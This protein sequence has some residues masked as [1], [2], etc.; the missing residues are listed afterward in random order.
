MENNKIQ[1]RP[2]RRT[3]CGMKLMTFLYS[4]LIDSKSTVKKLKTG[5]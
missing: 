1:K 4:L 5:T 3:A 2:V